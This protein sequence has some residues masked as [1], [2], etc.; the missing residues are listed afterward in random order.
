MAS[1]VRRMTLRAAKRAR[2]EGFTLVELLIVLLVA[3]LLV[4]AS[5]AALMGL[6]TRTTTEG[7]RLLASALAGCRDRAIAT[8]RAHGLRFEPDPSFGVAR[9]ADGSVDPAAV[10][11]YSRWTPIGPAPDYTEGL[12]TVRPGAAYAPAVRNPS[13][14]AVDVPS[15]VLESAPLDATGLLAP[16]TSW[17]WN[18]RV[19]DR[20]QLGGAGPWYAVAG[21]DWTGPSGNPERFVN[22]GAP[23]TAPPLSPAGTPV[24]WLVLVNARDDDANGWADEGF[25]GVDNDGNGLVDDAPEWE[26]EAW[27]GAASGGLVAARYAIRRR[28]MPTSDPSSA[29]AIPAQVVVDATGWGTTRARSRLPVDRYTGAVEVLVEPDGTIRY[30]LPYGV[31]ASV[32]MAAAYLHW[33]LSERGDVAAPPLATPA[34][35]WALVSASARTGR[36]GW[37]A[38]PDPTT[39]YAQA[40]QGVSD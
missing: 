31:P 6:R 36:V 28:P 13:G 2:R 27:H 17:A 10:L 8:G 40:Q 39:C 16:P 5:G 19:G 14:L 18:V 35:G 20:V 1:L 24:E 37:L 30:V 38:S 22:W 34:G 11:C 9:L 25:D 15:L 29:G 23:G 12:A 26:P 7:A 3:G 4:A 32:S 33:W 21:P